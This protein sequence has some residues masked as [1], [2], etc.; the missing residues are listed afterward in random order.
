MAEN[1]LFHRSAR[2]DI[3]EIFDCYA[4]KRAGLDAKFLLSLEEKINHIRVHPEIY[5]TYY[6]DVRRESLSHFPYVLYYRLVRKN[7]RVIAIYHCSRY[8]AVWEK[9]K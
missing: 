6:R 7:I 8:P 2:S 1:V 4:A 5:Q 9:R 3:I